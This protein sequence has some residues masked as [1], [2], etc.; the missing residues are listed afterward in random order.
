MDSGLIMG[1]VVF[2]VGDW[3]NDCVLDFSLKQTAGKRVGT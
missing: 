2:L 3:R 1:V